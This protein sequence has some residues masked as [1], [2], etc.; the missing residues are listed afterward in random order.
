MRARMALPYRY[1]FRTL[2]RG[3]MKPG[4]PSL[5][6]G[7]SSQLSVQKNPVA[8]YREHDM[9]YFICFF[10]FIIIFL[11]LLLFIYYLFSR[12][13]V[14]LVVNTGSFNQYYNTV[15]PRDNTYYHN[16]TRRQYTTRFKHK[17]PWD[18]RLKRP[19]FHCKVINDSGI[20]LS[21]EGNLSAI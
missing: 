17:R 4:M 1:R 21:V 9:R 20:M 6:H 15:Q 2:N 7:G 12:A 8:E 10:I 19:N 14:V 16:I 13:L 18:S 5:G 3:G 11:L